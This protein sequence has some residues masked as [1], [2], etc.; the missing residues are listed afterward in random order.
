MKI[1]S[2]LIWALALLAVAAA[3]FFLGMK[4]ENLKVE[5]LLEERLAEIEILEKKNQQLSEE[6]TSRGIYSYPQATV[7]SKLKAAVATVL[8]SLNG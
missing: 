1:N 4:K 7:V 3:S 2:D 8:I 6:L 5:E